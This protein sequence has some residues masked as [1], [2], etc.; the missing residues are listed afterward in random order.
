MPILKTL[1]HEE[2]LYMMMGGVTIQ[3]PSIGNN[4]LK[5]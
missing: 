4:A 1:Q 3:L 5:Q 2:H